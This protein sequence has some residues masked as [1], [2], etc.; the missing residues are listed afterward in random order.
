MSEATGLA[1]LFAMFLVTMLVALAILNRLK[2]L[3]ADFRQEAM[4]QRDFR[5]SSNGY[6][7]DITRHLDGGGRS[8]AQAA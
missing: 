5:K 1:S 8:E 2:K 7:S 6:F 4:W 3:A